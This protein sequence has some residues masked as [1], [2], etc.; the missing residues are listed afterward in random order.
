MTIPM[1]NQEQNIIFRYHSQCQMVE[2]AT[3]DDCYKQE[4][5]ENKI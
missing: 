2:L 5:Q 1:I 3:H 4:E